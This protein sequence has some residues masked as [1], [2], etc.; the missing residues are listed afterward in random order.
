MGMG[1]NRRNSVML[2]I[3]KQV[4]RNSYIPSNQLEMVEIDTNGKRG[5]MLCRICFKDD[6]FLLCGFDRK[7]DNHLLFPYFN[8]KK[9][10][11]S[12][13]D[14][15]LFVEDDENLFI[16]LIELKDSNHGPKKQTRISQTFAEFLIRR[17]RVIYGEDQFP[18]HVEYRSVGIKSGCLKM[19]TKGY[20]AL[21]YDKNGYVVLPDYHSFFIRRM[22]ELPMV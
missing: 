1:T 15:I 20:E 16:F 12:M 10:F 9:G 21:A 3:I 5:K 7:G 17:I 4:I 13:C 18:K 19:K 8:E 14:Y 22:K 2:D 6:E 11:V